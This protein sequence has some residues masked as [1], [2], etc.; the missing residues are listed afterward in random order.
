MNPVPDLFSSGL[1]PVNRTRDGAGDGQGTGR[2]GQGTG[3]N[4][5]PTCQASR[6]M[7]ME[8]SP[9]SPT[10]RSEADLSRDRLPSRLTPVRINALG[11]GS[12]RAPFAARGRTARA[13]VRRRQRALP[14]AGAT[15]D[16]GTVTCRMPSLCPPVCTSPIC[17]IQVRSWS[18]RMALA[19]FSGIA[20][21]SDHRESMSGH[22]VHSRSTCT[23]RGAPL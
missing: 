2:D 11:T 13:I 8:Q 23:P 18:L 17:H 9:I 10:P 5:H 15:H 4:G 3:S 20:C 14:K 19:T 6:Q 22:C 21:L 7:T 12:L 16:R 1:A